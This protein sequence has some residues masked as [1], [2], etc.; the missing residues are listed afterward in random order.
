MYAKLACRRRLRNARSWPLDLSPR[1]RRFTKGPFCVTLPRSSQCSRAPLIDKREHD[2]PTCRRMHQNNR[3][4]QVRSASERRG[5]YASWNAAKVKSIT[6]AS[7]RDC[8]LWH[9]AIRSVWLSLSLSLCGRARVSMYGSRKFP[10]SR[11]KELKIIKFYEKVSS[12][13]YSRT[14]LFDMLWRESSWIR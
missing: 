7:R 4:W 10:I 5:L 2:R 1:P 14:S 8:I 3:N 9:D 13:Y 6:M 12:S 11:A